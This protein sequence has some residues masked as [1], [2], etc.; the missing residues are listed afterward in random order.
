KDGGH[1]VVWRLAPT[2][3]QS[4]LANWGTM[5][6]ADPNSPPAA[7]LM[8]CYVLA[9]PDYPDLMPAVLTF[10]RSSIKQGRRLNTKLKTQ[11]TPIFGTVFTL[12]A[13][14]DTNSRG[15]DFKNVQM[16]GAGLVE[17]EGLYRQ[18]RDMHM[19]FKEAGLSIKD[20]EGLQ[21][22]AGEDGVNE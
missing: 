11:R 3:Q 9:F 4:G 15:Q 1:E 14:D 18:F 7:T 10:Q 17:D 6:P 8:Y 19:S 12:S 5:Y 2:V 16:T 22:A 21:G 13:F 20:I